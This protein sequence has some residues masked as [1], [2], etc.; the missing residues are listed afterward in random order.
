MSDEDDGSG[1]GR[2]EMGAALRARHQLSVVDC[3]DANENTPLSE[4]A[5]KNAL[6][7]QK[8]TRRKK[9]KM[10]CCF[11]CKQRMREPT[12]SRKVLFSVPLFAE[13]DVVKVPPR[14]AE[15]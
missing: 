8:S 12:I 7:E 3:E 5:S 2:D 11:V 10:L 13:I 6:R 4:A 15:G 1:V 14:N 9:R